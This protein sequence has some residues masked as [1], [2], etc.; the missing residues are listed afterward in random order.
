M[1]KKIYHF[2]VDCCYDYKKDKVKIEGV[3]KI[4]ITAI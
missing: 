4:K 1:N 3:E 2:Q